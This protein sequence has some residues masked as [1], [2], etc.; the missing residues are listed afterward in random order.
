MR[1]SRK[2]LLISFSLFC[3]LPAFLRA[4]E[5]LSA[6]TAEQL[7]TRLQ[8][9]SQRESELL[10]QQRLQLEKSQQRLSAAQ[11]E[12]SLAQRQ[13]QQAKSQ[14]LELSSQLRSLTTSLQMTQRSFQSYADAT[15]RTIAAQARSITLLK[16]GM[17]SLSVL[18]AGMLLLLLLK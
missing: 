5:D 11:A 4:A 18:G 9:N 17:V 10:Q 1:K 13:L 2:R 7:L 8:T 6:M 12:L 15:D 14:S 16:T 3:F